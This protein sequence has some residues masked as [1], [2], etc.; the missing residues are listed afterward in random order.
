MQEV[1]FVGEFIKLGQALKLAGAVENGAVAKTVI[2]DGEVIL[3]GE[4]DTRRGAKLF[5]GETFEF[6]GIK[7]L[8]VKDD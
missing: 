2:Q 1:H 7:Y 5:G 8:V 3:N 6:E 4:V